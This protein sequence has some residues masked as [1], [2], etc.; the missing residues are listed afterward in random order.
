MSREQVTREELTKL[1]MVAGNEKRYSYIVDGDRV[2]QWV[3]IGWVEVRRPTAE[4]LESLP[5]VVDARASYDL[6]A[7]TQDLVREIDAVLSSKGISTRLCDTN[8][9]WHARRV[10]EALAANSAMRINEGGE[11]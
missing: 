5:V 10:R 1:R 8:I 7:I 3:G 2:L 11:K 6:L 4:D 9:A